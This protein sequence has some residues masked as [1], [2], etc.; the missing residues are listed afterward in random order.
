MRVSFAA[1]LSLALLC[2][3]HPVLAQPSAKRQPG[4]RQRAAERVPT[5]SRKAA[6]G[7]RDLR[8]QISPLAR[9][10][11]VTALSSGVTY[12]S[13]DGLVGRGDISSPIG[14]LS[15]TGAVLGVTST[16]NSGLRTLRVAYPGQ[17]RRIDKRIKR[18]PTVRPWVRDARPWLQRMRRLLRRSLPQ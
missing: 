13:L 8:D 5:L 7:Y 9:H 17:A 18:M 3:S 1:A 16:L 2:L 15:L 4:L 6:N 11:S 10:V 12:A 14:L